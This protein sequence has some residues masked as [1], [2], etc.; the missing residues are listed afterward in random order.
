MFCV[1]AQGISMESLWEFARNL[2]EAHEQQV[3]SITVFMAIL[4]FCLVIGHLLGENRWVNESITALLIVIYLQNFH[5][6]NL[7]A[8]SLCF[9]CF[10]ICM[11]LCLD[12]DANCRGKGFLR[13]KFCKLS[14]ILLLTRDV[15]VER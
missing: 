14:F 12:I 10:S 13:F 15:S 9:W 4:C 1:I 5:F 2:R 11:V 7:H 3:V 8:T 6:S